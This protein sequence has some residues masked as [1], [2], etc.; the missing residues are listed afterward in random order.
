VIRKT[1]IRVF[2]ASLF[3]SGG[4]HAQ[5]S[6]TLAERVQKVVDRAEFKHAIFG[7]EFY[8]LDTGKTLF[9]MNADK[10]FVPGSTTKLLTEGT[11]LE[12]LGADYRFHTRVYRT[13]TVGPDGTL[14]GDLV[15]V[16]SG[17]PNLSG[18]IESDGTL[19]FGN[20]D[21][22]YA[23]IE[24]EGRAV[25]GNPLAVMN[26]LAQQVA[27]HRI[28][29]IKGR[30]FVDVSFFPEGKREAGTGVVVSPIAVN[31]NIIDVTVAPGASAGDPITLKASPETAYARFINHATIGKPGSDRELAWTSDLANSD[32]ARTVTLEGTLPAD[33]P[34]TI[35]PYSVPT[36]GRFAEI[37]FAEALRRAGV[38]VA[39]STGAR[40]ADLKQLAQSYTPESV[41]AEHVSPPLKEEVKVTLKVSQNLHAT[42]TP[43]ILGATLG[44]KND[45]PEQAGLD[46]EHDFLQKA[47]LD[48][49]GASQQEGAGG[50]GAYFTPDFMVHYLAFMAKQKDFRLFFDAL[51]VLGRDGTLWNV[52]VNSPAAGRVH[53]KTGTFATYDALNHRL[54][55]SGKGLAGYVETKDGRKLAFAAYV[56]NVS[57]PL[58]FKAVEKVGDALGEI[59]AAAYDAPSE[60]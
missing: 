34:A 48:L 7:I 26:E 38:V 59:A 32:G 60:R 30:V 40:I 20:V 49:T 37:A 2:L 18:R 51:P 28:K 15:L 52:Q 33:K 55:V 25:P 13:G 22:S 47:G 6:G 4:L 46:L 24:E 58:D 23:S 42:M 54:T 29:Q 57:T 27:A 8:S 1:A 19:A 5:S 44:R 50:P 12:L 10:L 9:K 35:F 45:D 14:D 31:D 3:V 53:A 43:L 11:A 41:V 39:V 16:A 36:P 56:N 21:H 17:D